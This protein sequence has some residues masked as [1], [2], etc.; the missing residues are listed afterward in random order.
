MKRLILTIGLSGA[1]KFIKVGFAD[2]ALRLDRQLAWGPP[3]SA[4]E[5][6]AFFAAPGDQ[7]RHFHWHDYS[8]AWLLENAGA[9]GL[10]LMEC[11]AECESVALWI[12][13]E[14]SAQ[15]LLTWLLD[16]LRGHKEHMF[17][18][19]LIQS[20]SPL[21]D[22]SPDKLARSQAPAVKILDEHLD[23]VSMA[24]RA[25]CAP[26]PTAWRDL[27]DRDL[28]VLPQLRQSVVELLEELPSSTVGLGATEMRMLELISE[29]HSTPSQLFSDRR[30][31]V[32]DYWEIGDV[33]DGLARCPAPAVSGLD[34]GP[35]RDVYLHR[36][37]AERYE[38]SKLSLTELGKAI[39]AGTED[40]TRHNPIHRWWGGTELTNDRLWR[41]DATNKTLIA[42]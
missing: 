18:L 34:E 20:D 24:W 42:P 21:G 9:K 19:T 40:F 25:Y 17:R 4:A 23:L 5:T 12:D 41:W 16:Y 10:G 6:V 22:Q 30:R 27:L 7:E 36:E 38:Q 39:L 31:R 35:F 37:R 28:V 3:P 33:L 26:T 1:N 11:F 29:G 32:F 15:L 13:P 2:V 14:P 8:P